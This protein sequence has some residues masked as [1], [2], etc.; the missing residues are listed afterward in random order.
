MACWPKCTCSCFYFLLVLTSP[1]VDVSL[2]KIQM[3]TFWDFMLFYSLCPGDWAFWNAF[4][5][6]ITFCL[7]LLE[8]SC[9]LASCLREN[10]HDT[11][12]GVHFPQKIFKHFPR[13]NSRYPRC[14]LPCKFF[15]WT[16]SLACDLKKRPL[17]LHV[18]FLCV[19]L[20]FCLGYG[21]T[22]FLLSLLIST[23]YF[24]RIYISILKLEME[25]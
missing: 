9:L 25:K 19:F 7:H 18:T 16:L 4:S 15:R 8:S 5:K 22:G 13:S 17:C 20:W 24:I 1:L 11:K 14:D 23:L 12:V 6:F 2:L 21:Y 10:I 3:Y